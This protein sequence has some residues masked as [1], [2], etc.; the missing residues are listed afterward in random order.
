M[1]GID[2]KPSTD[3]AV[4]QPTETVEQAMNRVLQAERDAEQAVEACRR[5]AVEIRQAA[6]LRA[7]RIAERTNERLAICH[8]RC[9]SKLRHALREQERLSASQ[10]GES[11]Y[12]LD[13]A[14]LTAVVEALARDL[15]GPDPAAGS[16][17]RER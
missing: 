12:R 4:R 6:Q 16:P 5:E 9:N 3:A 7:R 11:S 1:T 17:H 2:N 10:T 15:T 8:M 13:A 14:A